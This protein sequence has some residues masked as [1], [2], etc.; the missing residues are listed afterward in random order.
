MD[1]LFETL[2]I[3]IDRTPRDG[4]AQMAIDEVLLEMA[5][6]PVLRHYCWSGPWVSFGYAQSARTAGTQWPAV[7]RW[8]GGGVVPHTGDWTFAL[9]VPRGCPFATERPAET[10]RFIHHA[11]AESLKAAGI[12]AR[13]ATDED[14][15][16]GSACFVSPASHDILSPE[17]TKLS[18]GAQRR[19]RA[20]F[21]HQGSIQ[22]IPLPPEFALSFGRQMAGRTEDFVPPSHLEPREAVL[23]TEKY[24]SAEWTFKIP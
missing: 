17:G 12:A 8:T 7:R 22:N 10:Y 6:R 3:W 23:A 15:V 11:L 13:L 24:G 19:T 2:E 4:P 16:A 20:G 9:I 5:A 18:G 21:L 1:K 14:R